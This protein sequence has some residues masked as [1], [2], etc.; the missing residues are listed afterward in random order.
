MSDVETK[1]AS[2]PD[3]R[4]TRREREEDLD[5]SFQWGVDWTWRNFRLT[6]AASADL[7]LSYLWTCLDA[8]LIF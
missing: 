2:H 4:E 1:R 5:A 8:R 7:D 6:G 3:Y